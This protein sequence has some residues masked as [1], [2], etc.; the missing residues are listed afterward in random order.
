MT[1]TVE[2]IE[3]GTAG[4]LAGRSTLPVTD[5]VGVSR[6]S[7]WGPVAGLSVVALA[8]RL[9]VVR[10][11][12]TGEATGGY[13]A[14]RSFSAFGHSLIHSIAAPGVPFILWTVAHTVGST[15]TD[16]RLPS[17]LFGALSIPMLYLAGKALYSE[18]AGLTVAAI[19]TVG[20]TAVWY[21]QEASASALLMLLVTVTIWS[22]RRALTSARGRY[23]VAWAAAAGGM[24]WVEWDSAAVVGVEVLVF[25]TMVVARR[26]QRQQGAGVRPLATAVAVV[27]VVAVTVPGVALLIDQLRSAA[28]RGDEAGGPVLSATTGPLSPYGILHGLVVAV[29]GYHSPGVTGA[30]V[31]L[32]PVGLLGLLLVLG[33]TQHLSHWLLLALVVVPA[34]A[35]GTAGLLAGR[36]LLHAGNLVGAVPAIYLLVAGVIWTAAPSP[37][38][39]RIVAAGLLV[40][41]GVG[42]VSQQTDS[43]NPELYGYGAAFRQ[44]ASVA[45]PG[46]EIVYTPS[47][48]GETVGYFAPGLRRSPLNRG[49]SHAVV[50][51]QV[52][53][54]GS[55]AGTTGLQP[56]GTTKLLLHGLEKTRRLVAV[57]HAPHV[58]VW[59]LS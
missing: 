55:F 22:Q 48:I 39:S 26:R 18:R 31:A 44:I 19:G 6:H 27:A 46:A 11:F 58:V 43:R 59:E 51:R 7:A 5:R 29:W 57:F 36:D 12:S 10:N 32:W 13:A 50:A 56:L 4:R 54:V 24:V 35:L 15:E 52:F 23:L 8:L 20:A 40:V 2:L 34:A 49:P 17:I 45:R 37:A 33:R 25:A 9:V 28:V 16:L 53:V 41:L 14:R 3:A 1:S 21:S 47:S 42:L 30:A 38:A